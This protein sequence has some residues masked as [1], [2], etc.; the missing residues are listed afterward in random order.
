M[1]ETTWIQVAEEAQAY[2]QASIDRCQSITQEVAAQIGDSLDS[3][4]L[5]GISKKV[6]SSEELEI[7]ESL[8]EDLQSALAG[9]K[10]SATA[11]TTA[12]LKR[13]VVAQYAVC[14]TSFLP[15]EKSDL[16]RPIAS[17]SSSL[18]KLW[19]VPNILIAFSLKTAKLRDLCTDFPSV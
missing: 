11:V 13:A 8:P 3:T 6:L 10:Y 19:N 12:F 14:V 16:H 9:K 4:N 2:R 15:R 5:S 18:S 1:T 7:T 17:P